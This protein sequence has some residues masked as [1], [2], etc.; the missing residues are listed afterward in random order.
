MLPPRIKEIG[1]ALRDPFELLGDERR[2]VLNSNL[3]VGKRANQRNGRLVQK[4]NLREIQYDAYSFSEE[5]VAES[6][7][8]LHPRPHNLAFQMED[9]RLSNWFDL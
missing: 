7:Q 2:T 4:R 6:L 8:F 5:C 1:L 3:T 9:S